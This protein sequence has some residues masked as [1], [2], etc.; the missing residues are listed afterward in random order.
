LT[1]IAAAD[2]PVFEVRVV[3]SDVEVKLTAA[4]EASA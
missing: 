4:P 1:A 2:I 3:G